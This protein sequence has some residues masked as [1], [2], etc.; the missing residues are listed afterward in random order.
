MGGCCKGEDKGNIA[1]GQGT[2]KKG[3]EAT[4][5]PNAATASQDQPS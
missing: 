4:A 5:D 2:K 1:V 3:E